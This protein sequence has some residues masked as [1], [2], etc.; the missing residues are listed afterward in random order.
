MRVIVFGA[1]GFLGGWVSEVLSSMTEIE[2]IACVRKWASAVRLARRG[3]KVVPVD[4]DD[5]AA[6]DTVLA[7]ANAVINAA[8][9]PP[10]DEPRVVTA[11]YRASLRAGV[12]RFVQ[13]SS[14]AVYGEATGLVR[15]D[16]PPTPIDDYGRCKAEME[17]RLVQLASGSGTQVIV[18]RPSIIYGAFSESWT[19]RYV[20]RVIRGGWLTLGSLGR[21]NCNLVHARDIAQA[22]IAAATSEEVPPGTH[23]L[24]ING[25]EILSWNDYIERL[26]DVLG[27]SRRKVPNTVV[28]RGKALAGDMARRFGAIKLVKEFYRNSVGSTR[29]TMKTAQTFAKIYPSRKEL[30]L[31]GRKVYYSAESAQ[32][33]LNFTPAT[34]LDEG[35]RESVTWCRAHGLV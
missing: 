34:R 24:N 25:P 19:I 10:S 18:L 14:A 32:K 22:S 35:V 21:G 8:L 20:E 31:L 33:I 30:G 6:I 26:G 1:G 2:Q 11:L 28:F 27:V 7:G 23:V 3:L 17:R 13:F 29:E 15:E 12:R 9:P 4:V 5:A 16:T